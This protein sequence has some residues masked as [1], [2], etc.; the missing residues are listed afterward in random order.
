MR[1]ES[2]PTARGPAPEVPTEDVCDKRTHPLSFLVSRSEVLVLAD[3]E[4]RRS[5]LPWQATQDEARR[6]VLLTWTQL[7]KSWF[8]S[9]TNRKSMGL[10][11]L[12]LGLSPLAAGELLLAH[13]SIS[14]PTDSFL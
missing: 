14:L 13:M 7:P 9:T 6:G 11:L 2:C 4:G 8:F 5:G 1:A 3:L 10:A 12:L